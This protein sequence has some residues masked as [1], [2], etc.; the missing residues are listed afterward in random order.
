MVITMQAFKG[1]FFNI[2]FYYIYGIQ[3]NT[4]FHLTPFLM[5]VILELQ[6]IIKW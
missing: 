1:F 3:E 4:K 6:L 5:G 2:L